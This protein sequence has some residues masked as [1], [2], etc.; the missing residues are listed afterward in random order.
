M[1]STYAPNYNANFGAQPQMSQQNMGTGAYSFN[2]NEPP[3]YN[4]QP[5]P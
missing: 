1:P 2:M 3:K 5:A 4:P